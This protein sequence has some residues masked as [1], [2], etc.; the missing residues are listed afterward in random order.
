MRTL[1]YIFGN[2]DLEIDNLPLQI[3][4][5]LRSSFPDIEFIVKD[6]NEEW[7]IP[8]RFIVIDTVLG[9]PEPMRFDDLK[10]FASVPRFTVHDFDAL[11][12][13]RLLDKLGR[14]GEVRIIG[15]PPETG[16]A[17]AIAFCTVHLKELA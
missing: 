15:L 8:E 2:P 4:P 7:E 13:L 16:K 6:P 5:E 10:Q 14:L 9:I 12:N 3:L 11:T 1:V 17:E